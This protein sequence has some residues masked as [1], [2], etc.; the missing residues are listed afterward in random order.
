MRQE[1]V[2]VPIS[3]IA[4]IPQKEWEK[5]TK[6]K[7]KVLVE[8]MGSLG[9]CA[10][11]WIELPGN[12][13]ETCGQ[14]K[15]ELSIDHI[16]CVGC[17]QHAEIK[18]AGSQGWYHRVPDNN[19]FENIPCLTLARQNEP[20]CE[21]CQRRTLIKYDSTGHTWYHP[22]LLDDVCSRGTRCQTM[23]STAL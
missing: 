7:V 21:G 12:C 6:L 9:T 10:L 8:R 15:P 16:G 22:F 18:W 2:L 3:L 23:N 11:D 19:D 17:K 5:C 13:C 14:P 1:T 4:E 20:P